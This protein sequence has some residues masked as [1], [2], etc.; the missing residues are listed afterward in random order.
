MGYSI[1]PG[2]GSVVYPS[3]EIARGPAGCVGVTFDRQMAAT[4]N[5]TSLLTSGTLLVAPMVLAVGTTVTNLNFKTGTTAATAPTNW[6]LGLWNL[7]TLALIANTADQLTGA[8]AASTI[9]TKALTSAYLV[10]ASGTYLVGLMVAATTVP[11]LAAANTAPTSAANGSSIL[12]V[13]NGNSSAG[14]T[15]LPAPNPAG[16]IT[17]QASVPLI[18]AT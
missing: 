1:S 13:F 6:W 3:T 4:A 9:F 16:A 17:F 18:W 10:P 2:V 15:V 8:I 5:N 12:P 7:S 14:L 11:T